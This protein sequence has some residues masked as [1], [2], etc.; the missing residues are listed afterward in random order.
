[1]GDARA[2]LRPRP[3]ARRGYPLGPRSSG[4]RPFGR[5]GLGILA[6]SGAGFPLTQLAIAR[7]G[8]RGAMFVEALV[9]GLLL[10][11]IGLI[12][13]GTPSR[14]RAGPAALLWA[15]AAAA[16]AAA[17]AGA[18]LLRDPEVAAARQAGWAVGRG[19]LFRRVAVGTLFGLHTVRF[20][21]RLSPGAGRR[22]PSPR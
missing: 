13:S 12:V 15:E 19:E 17:M 16:A 18:L 2:L 20:R 5:V 1:M 11:D 8:R 4:A 22:P 3:W 6:L 21:T 7:F 14:L 9:V 10:R